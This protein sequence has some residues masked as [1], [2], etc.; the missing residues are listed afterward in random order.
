[1][2]KQGCLLCVHI[3]DVDGSSPEFSKGPVWICSKNPTYGNL[4]SF[5]FKKEMPCLER[6]PVESFLRELETDLLIPAASLEDIKKTYS[7]D[8]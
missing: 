2:T 4:L 7:G 1:M 8:N 5:P 6:F 3:D